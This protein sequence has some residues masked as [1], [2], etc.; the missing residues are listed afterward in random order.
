VRLD[1]EEDDD[2]SESS[3]FDGSASEVPPDSGKPGPDG[4]RWVYVPFPGTHPSARRH[5]PSA[6]TPPLPPPGMT[7]AVRLKCRVVQESK[8][9]SVGEVTLLRWCAATTLCT[10]NTRLSSRLKECATASRASPRVRS[11]FSGSPDQPSCTN[12]RDPS[13][14]TQAPSTRPAAP[15]PHLHTLR[16]PLQW[17][18]RCDGHALFFGIKFGAD[19]RCF[20][21]PSVFPVPLHSVERI[22]KQLKRAKKAWGKITVNVHKYRS[23][24][25]QQPVSCVACNES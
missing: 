17:R 23:Q 20:R 18:I 19:K 24:S 1:N 15:R 2:S 11:R 4:G 6:S 21:S 22:V 3:A 12:R 5:S 7:R 25:S 13:P 10:S 16:L 14:P 8:R 9:A